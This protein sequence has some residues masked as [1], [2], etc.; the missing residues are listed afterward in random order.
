M[1]QIKKMKPIEN[2]I[3][4]RKLCPDLGAVQDIAETTSYTCSQRHHC[5]KYFCLKILGLNTTL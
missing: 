4:F 5:A 2:I 1:G 3:L